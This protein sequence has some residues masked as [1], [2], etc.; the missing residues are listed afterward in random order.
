[1]FLLKDNTEPIVSALFTKSLLEILSDGRNKYRRFPLPKKRGGVR[2]ISEPVPEL[3]AAQRTILE[4]L[5]VPS[6][7]HYNGYEVINGFMPGRSIVDNARPHV[8][9]QVVLSMDLKDF[10]GSLRQVDLPHKFCEDQ[11]LQDLLQKVCFASK[12]RGLPQGSPVSPMLANWAG[13]ALDERI[14][15]DLQVLGYGNVFRH[16]VWPHIQYT[17]YADDLTFSCAQD[18]PRNFVK[19]MQACVQSTFGRRLKFADNKIKFMRRHKRQ[20]VTG[21]VVNEKLSIP[22]ERRKVLRAV[23]HRIETKGIDSVE[24]FNFPELMGELSYFHLTDKEKAR[25]MIDMLLAL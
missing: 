18:I 12:G 15:A 20:M 22:K 9:Q 1:M 17:R 25:D 6:V 19:H 7:R 5:N 16:A 21:I 8:G 11:A 23:K 4:C 2:W 24:N 13:K 10:F 3:K 14:I